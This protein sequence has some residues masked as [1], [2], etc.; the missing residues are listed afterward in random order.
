MGL[1][2][3]LSIYFK[4]QL[5]NVKIRLEYKA[6]FFIMLLTGMFTQIVGFLFLW[7][8]FSRI[9]AIAGWGMW[10]IVMMLASIFFTEG[11]VSF[12]FEGM[13]RMAYVVN[14]GEFDRFLLRPVSPIVQCFTYD[15]GIHGIGNM[16]MGIVLFVVALLNTPLRWD[17][18]KILYMPLYVIS[19]AALRTAI[20]LAANSAAFWLKTRASIFPV[21]ILQTADFA[22]YPLQIFPNVIQFVMIFLL[23]YAFISYIP[24][25][26]LLDKYTWA[27]TAWLLPVVA[28]V[29]IQISRWIFNTG[30]SRYESPGN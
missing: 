17:V 5:Q 28:L 9:P 4:M 11:V 13:W 15:L 24:V 3:N 30:L 27:W 7:V 26:Y 1:G 18:W 20:S 12:F 14:S 8:V 16:T 25:S 6:D 2:K 22:K 10:E 29:F 21:M 23:P 19:A